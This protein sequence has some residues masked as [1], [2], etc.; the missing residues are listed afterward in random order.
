MKQ[1]LMSSRKIYNQKGWVGNIGPMIEIDELTVSR[2]ENFH[3]KSG[4]PDWTPCTKGRDSVRMFA[5]DASSNVYF[6]DLWRSAYESNQLSFVQGQDI[7]IISFYNT[8]KNNSPFEGTL[9]GHDTSREL[10][11][12]AAIIT[13]NKVAIFNKQQSVPKYMQE[14]LADKLSV[15]S[16]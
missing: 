6:I 5:I 1:H 16:K 3:Q 4:R 7:K 15:N 12:I 8:K 10:R 11:R 13:S 14:F 9:F 2:L